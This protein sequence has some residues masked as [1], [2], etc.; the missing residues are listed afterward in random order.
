MSPKLCA[1]LSNVRYWTMFNIFRWNRYEEI[2]VTGRECPATAPDTL[3]NCSEQLEYLMGSKYLCSDVTSAFNE[4]L[5][6]SIET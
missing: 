1:L 3:V 2:D 5:F 4:I 6:H